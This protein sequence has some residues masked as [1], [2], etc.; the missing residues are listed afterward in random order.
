MAVRFLKTSLICTI[1]KRE[2][3]RLKGSPIRRLQSQCWPNACTSC[4]PPPLSLKLDVRLCNH[5]NVGASLPHLSGGCRVE[6]GTQARS[7]R[8]LGCFRRTEIKVTRVRQRLP[9]KH[10][11]SPLKPS[12][13]NAP[14]WCSTLV[15]FC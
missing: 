15:T 6:I 5:L 9:K 8:A 10:L 11:L 13:R 2:E 12:K 7:D 14:G 1:K 3:A 4:S